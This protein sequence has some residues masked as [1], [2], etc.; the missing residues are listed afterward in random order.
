[1]LRPRFVIYRPI[2]QLQPATVPLHQHLD[3]ELLFITKGHYRCRHNGRPVELATGDALLVAP[4]DWHE[5]LLDRVPLHYVA[6]CFELSTPADG[7]LLCTEPDLSLQVIRQAPFA[8][9][10]AAIDHEYYQPDG[11]SPQ[12]RQAALEHLVWNLVRALPDAVLRPELVASAESGDALRERIDA[13]FQ[14][15][16]SERLDV[17]TMAEKL[18][19]SRRA[20]SAHCAELFGEGPAKAFLRAKLSYAQAALRDTTMSVS[21]VADYLGFANPYHFS[22]AY[23]RLHGQSPS[24]DKLPD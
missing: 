2:L 8:Q 12:V 20:L 3:H 14:C 11:V 5:D 19:M 18:S 16:L 23:K 15:H 10:F 6:V 4:G 13:L 21:Q 17:N 24:S 9:A 22:N 7:H 1:M